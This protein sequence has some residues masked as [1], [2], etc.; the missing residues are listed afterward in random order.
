[1]VQLTLFTYLFIYLLL[2]FMA[3]NNKEGEILKPR[4]EMQ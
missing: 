1:M 2:Q 3:Y 4:D